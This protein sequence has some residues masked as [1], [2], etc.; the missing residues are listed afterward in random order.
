MDIPSNYQRGLS[1]GTL[2]GTLVVCLPQ[3]HLN[4][5]GFKPLPA[6]QDIPLDS[7]DGAVSGDEENYF[8]NCVTSL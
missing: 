1:Q 4:S 7:M 8:L 6:M 5:A 2:P 3:V